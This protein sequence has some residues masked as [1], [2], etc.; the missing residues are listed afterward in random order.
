MSNGEKV[1]HN[2]FKD[3]PPPDPTKIEWDHATSRK[4]IYPEIADQL[5]CLYKDID[6]GL[7]GKEAKTGSFYLAIK[8]VKETHPVGS[9]HKPYKNI[10]VSK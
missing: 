3:L 1:F 4:K 6:N 8:Q 9:I 7:F 10:K 2:L 5:D